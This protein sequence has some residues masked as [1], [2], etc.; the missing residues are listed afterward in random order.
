VLIDADGK[1]L[2]EPRGHNLDIQAF[3]DWLDLGVAKFN[4]P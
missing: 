1:P 4:T 2:A 3:R